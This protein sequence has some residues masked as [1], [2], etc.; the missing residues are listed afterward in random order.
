MSDSGVDRAMVDACLK[1]MTFEDGEGE[2]LQVL[3]TISQISCLQSAR[4]WMLASGCC[5]FLPATGL[6]V[7]SLMIFD[8][9]SE[10]HHV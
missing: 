5:H 7:C 3:S 8:G 2:P 10:S 9:Q 4:C 1:A 6:V